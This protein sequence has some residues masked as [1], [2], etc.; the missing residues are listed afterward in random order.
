MYIGNV[1]GIGHALCTKREQQKKDHYETMVA[2]GLSWTM[3]LLFMVLHDKYRFGRNRLKA[4]MDFFN[5]ID[6]D[7]TQPQGF[8]F[9]WRDMLD[10]NG[11]ERMKTE[12]LAEKLRRALL[13]RERDKRCI[14]HTQD[15]IAGAMIVTAYCLYTVYGFRKKRLHD[16]QAYVSDLVYL[17]A[18]K[19]IPI[20]E[21][22]ECLYRECGIEQDILTEYK[23]IHGPIVI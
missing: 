2:S 6:A 22:M 15:I 14:V 19:E 7:G 20:W 9:L 11:F 5:T 8:V 21:F 23:R 10:A 17:V 18:K 1:C 3:T 13:D 12:Y 4:V 16:F